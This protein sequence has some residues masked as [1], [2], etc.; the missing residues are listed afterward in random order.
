LQVSGAAAGLTV[1]VL[2][3]VQTFGL[4]QMGVA[5]LL[6]GLLQV[7]GG[8]AK[9]GRWFQAASPTVILGMLSGIGVLI[10]VGQFHVMLDIAAKGNGI[11]NIK[12]I[13]ESL[14]LA[15][16]PERH[17]SLS[18]MALGILT[19]ALMV[20][21]P[22]FGRR[23]TAFLPA[24]LVAIGVSV[25]AAAIFRIDVKYVVIPSDLFASWQAFDFDF[26]SAIL[27]PGILGLAIQLA[28]I[29]SAESLLCAAAT[30]QMH[31]GPRANFDKE[32]ISQ[33]VGNLVCGAL[34]ALPM[35]GVIVRSS[36]NVQAGAVS[37][38]SAMLHGVWLLLFVAVLPGV[39]GSIPTA[40]LAGLLVFTGIK[41]LNVK[42]VTQ[43]FYRSKSE[44]A[45]FLV[46]ATAVVTV[47]LL[48]GVILGL[49]LAGIKLLHALSHLQVNLEHSPDGDHLVVDLRGAATFVKLP[50]LTEALESLPKGVNVTLRSEGL[51]LV[52]HACVDHIKAW[53]KR[54]EQHGG[55]ISEEGNA[56]FI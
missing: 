8:F 1:I 52:D 54:H 22:I 23:W 28:L 44:L 53:R 37:R 35:T 43:L 19:I 12:A 20:T 48:S 7:I 16:S 2:Q 30:D 56:I 36:A 11:L 33:G 15:F 27:N 9:V 49:A 17:Q 32:L 26:R 47:D 34:G 18:A 45:I 41:L 29:A 55:T 14:A 40:A 25:L 4:Q 13:P 10:M 24:P 3:G 6:A 39:L 42:A 21:W 31:N 46:T 5:I 51:H 50:H 38:W